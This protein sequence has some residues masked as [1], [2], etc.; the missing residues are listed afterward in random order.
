MPSLEITAEK[1]P[2]DLDVFLKN[3]STLFSECIGKPES[4]CMVIFNKVD[5]VYFNGSSGAA[6]LAKITSIGNIDNE[7]NANLSQKI[8]EQLEKEL[9]VSLERGYFF[10]NNAAA[11]DTGYKATTFANLLKK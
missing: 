4:Y 9:G 7:R 10:F 1:A 3:L 6:F 5:R 2:A 8:G 11:S